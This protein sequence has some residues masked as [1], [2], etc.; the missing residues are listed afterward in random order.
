MKKF[1]LLFVMC[2][3]A[4][5]VSAQQYEGNIGTLYGWG[6]NNKVNNFGITTEH[7]YRFNDYLFIGAGVGFVK[8]QQL[9]IAYIPS[10]LNIKGYIWNNRKITP[11]ASFDIGIALREESGLLMSPSIGCTYRLGRGLGLSLSIGYN[12]VNIHKQPYNSMNLKFAF[13]F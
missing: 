10:Y 3:Y 8:L 5:L 6:F 2:I 11:F 13:N 4:Q 9:S 7:G 12:R 1:F